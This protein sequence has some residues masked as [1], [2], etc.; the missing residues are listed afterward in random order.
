MNL[1]QV[2][3]FLICLIG[4]SAVA[5]Q[6]GAHR[7]TQIAATALAAGIPLAVLQSTSPRN[8]LILSVWL[9]SL[10]WFGWR[11]AAQ[12]AS[13]LWLVGTGL[14]LGL[15]LLTKATAFV[16]AFPVVCDGWPRRRCE[17][18]VPVSRFARGILVLILALA[19]NR[20]T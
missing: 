7:N 14:S 9:L 20:D 4:V 11:W 10:V 2:G 6:L 5:Q 19:F 1:I 15:A 17:R 12:P 16:F 13:W 3:A 18:A 8:D